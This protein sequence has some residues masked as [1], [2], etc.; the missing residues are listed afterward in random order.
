MI[1]GGVSS[2][3]TATH[4]PPVSNQP[5]VLVSVGGKW[6]ANEVTMVTH[7]HPDLDRP[8]SF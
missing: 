7:V 2:H 5:L 8:L 4:R 6:T 1:G 3:W